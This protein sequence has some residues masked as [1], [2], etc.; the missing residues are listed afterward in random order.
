M[1]RQY[2]ILLDLLEEDT[3]RSRAFD[4]AARMLEIQS[5]SLDELIAANRLSSIRGIGKGVAATILE[6]HEHGTFSDLDSAQERVPS[7]VI[8]LLRVDGLGPKKARSLWKDAGITSLA[9]LENAIETG[10]L[11]KLPGFGAKTA[12]RFRAGLAFIKTVS[13]R[14]WRHHAQRAADS[15]LESLRAVSFIDEV[16]F[17]GSLRRGNETVGD[18]DVLVVAQ[19]AQ[20]DKI[21]HQ[22]VSLSSVKWNENG[23]MLRGVTVAGFP[24]ELSVV[25]PQEAAVRKILATGSKEHVAALRELA[26]KRGIPL[27]PT[28]SPGFLRANTEN[29]VYGAFGLACTPPALREGKNSLYPSGAVFPDPV[30]VD[31]IRGILH[32][33]T[34]ASD[35]HHTLREMAEAMIARGFE[36]LGIADHSQTASYARGLTPDRVRAQ[37]REIDA[38]NAEMAPFRILKGTESDILTSGALDFD[39]ELLA[40]FDY[41]VASVHS[42]FNMTEEQATDRLCRAIENPHMDIL[43]HATGRLLLERNGYPVNHERLI[44]CAAMYG[45]AIELNSSPHRLDLDWRHLAQCEAEKVPVPLCPDAHH[46]DGL[47]DIRWGVDTA[48]KGQ[49]TAANCPSTWPVEQFLDWCGSHQ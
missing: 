32:C 23:G 4:N 48:A 46:I 30:R 31:Q 7:G 8:D 33:H 49:L 44:A 17:G 21:R 41:V 14:H 9:S 15:L 27:D 6:I 1:L 43:G 26:S 40:G 13:G 12:E 5:E 11:A 42:G 37:W 16:F 47:W 3:F 45:K 36:Y 29:D 38:L 24:I 20:I 28:E 19:A 18:L 2:A 25:P 39:D 10:M 22:I 35:G 34:T